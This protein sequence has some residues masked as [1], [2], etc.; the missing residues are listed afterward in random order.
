MAANPS[1]GSNELPGELGELDSL[2]MVVRFL[3]AMDRDRCDVR[4]V[5]ITYITYID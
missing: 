4:V 1:Q 2:E 5:C 3:V